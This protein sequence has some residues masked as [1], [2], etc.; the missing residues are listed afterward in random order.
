MPVT[1]RHLA[2]F[3]ALA[4]E[5]SFAR[6][7]ERVHVSQP[8]LSMQIRDL[9]AALG[10]VLVERNPRDLRLTP[11]GRE[12]LLR[13]ARVL[14]EVRDLEALGRSAGQVGRVQIGVIPTVAPYL[15]PPVLIL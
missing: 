4:A 1:L 13:A 12:V 6:A 3:T 7:A 10:V 8:A 15:L 5:K 9:E 11:A 2:Y 14:A